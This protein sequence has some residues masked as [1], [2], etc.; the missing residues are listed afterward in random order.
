MKE[1]KKRILMRTD[2][3]VPFVSH[4]VRC[5]SHMWWYFVCSR[6]KNCTQT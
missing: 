2:I 4:K 3:A 5:V 6:N 1:K